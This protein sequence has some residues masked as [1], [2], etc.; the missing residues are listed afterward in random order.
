METQ[1]AEGTEALS[2]LTC[3]GQSLGGR[4]SP[5]GL[6]LSWSLSVL[7]Q[8]APDFRSGEVRIRMG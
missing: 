3:P 4:A 5:F 6:S 7:C 1:A 2:G 8:F